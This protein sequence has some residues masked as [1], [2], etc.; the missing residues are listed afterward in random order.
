VS[1][2]RESIFTA[3]SVSISALSKPVE[4]LLYLFC[5]LDRSNISKDLFQRACSA[6]SHWNLHGELAMLAPSVQGVPEW[7]LTLFCDEVGVWSDFR[8]HKAVS[9]I[10]SL[11]FVQEEIFSGTWLHSTGAAETESLAADGKMLTLLRIPQPVYD[12]GRYCQMA[13]PRRRLCYD[14]FSI[15]LQ[16]FVNPVPADC[17]P[18]GGKP[19]MHVGRGGLI[20]KPANLQRRLE[21]AYGHIFVCKDDIRRVKFGQPRCFDLTVP[22]WE[23]AEVL[24]FAAIYWPELRA[25]SPESQAEEGRGYGRMAGPALPDVQPPW[26]TLIS[27]T[28]SIIRQPS[29]GAGDHWDPR[30][31]GRWRVDNESGEFTFERKGS[32]WVSTARPGEEHESDDPHSELPGWAFR[33]INSDPEIK[34]AVRTRYY[35]EKLAATRDFSQGRFGC[36]RTSAY[37]IAAFADAELAT[38]SGATVLERVEEWLRTETEEAGDGERRNGWFGS[39]LGQY[40]LLRV[41]PN[42]RAGQL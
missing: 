7:L 2:Y 22:L 5:L 33:D 39:D 20:E 29:A 42:P 35:H 11:F 21:E 12:F 38:Q 37:R 40:F 8:F 25:S 1:G 17:L 28:E 16:G 6:K 32:M 36:L 26:E 27:W 15:V 14:V 10:S 19:L 34:W 3:W 9:E 13:E 23:R 18:A 41:E 30:T 4:N 24:M 31:S